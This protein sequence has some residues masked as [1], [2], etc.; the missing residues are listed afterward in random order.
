[1]SLHKVLVSLHLFLM[2]N[3]LLLSWHVI[4]F[5]LHRLSDLMLEALHISI[6][7]GKTFINF[8]NVALRF[9]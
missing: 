5:L 4:C 3:V 6:L 9:I 8:S 7:M 1:M 2:C